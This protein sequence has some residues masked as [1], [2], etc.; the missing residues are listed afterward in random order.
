MSVEWFNARAGVPI[1]SV[2]RNGLVF[3]PLSRT[4]MGDPQFVRIGVDALTKRLCVKATDGADEHALPFG[5]KVDKN[6][7]VRLTRRDIA[8]F[9]VSRV[10]GLDLA[11][12]RKCLASWNEQAG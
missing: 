5:K 4:V 10:H 3:T 7:Y 9:I 11:R 12:S 8:R 1:V 2:G 6:G